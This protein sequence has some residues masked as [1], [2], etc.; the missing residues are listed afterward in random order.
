[1]KYKGYVG[2]V[3]Y[4]D[5]DKILHGRV[6][7]I[8]RD[9][10]SFEGSTVKEIEKDFRAAIDDYLEFK[11]ERGEAPEEPFSGKFILRI[12]SGSINPRRV[13]HSTVAFPTRFAMVASSRYFS[14]IFSLI[15]SPS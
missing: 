6:V 15:R 4:D 8:T 2:E 1:M 11:S 12:P 14:S 7:N 3:K 5:R 10:I 13:A 9:M